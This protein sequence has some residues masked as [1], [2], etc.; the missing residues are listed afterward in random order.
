MQGCSG[1]S[2]GNESCL[3][4]NQTPPSTA[5]SNKKWSRPFGREGTFIADE[6]RSGGVAAIEQPP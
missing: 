6:E 2:L 5:R 1:F 4:G 3:R